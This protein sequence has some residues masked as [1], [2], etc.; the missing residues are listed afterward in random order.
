MAAWHQF[1][2]DEQPGGATTAT[3]APT[4]FG[5]A[6]LDRAAETAACLRAQVAFELKHGMGAIGGCESV[7]ERHAA[8]YDADEQKPRVL[9]DAAH[10]YNSAGP[11]STRHD[12]VDA[13]HPSSTLRNRA[14]APAPYVSTKPLAA[15]ARIFGSFTWRADRRWVAGIS[16]HG[17]VLGCPSIAIALAALAACVLLFKI[18]CPPQ[19]PCGLCQAPALRC[20]DRGWAQLIVWSTLGF[21]CIVGAARPEDPGRPSPA[22]VAARD[23]MFARHEEWPHMSGWR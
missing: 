10:W 23:I 3:I 20:G 1:S 4:V 19:R 12:G 11:E 8:A 9:N 17:V 21:A 6:A 18:A 2:C 5:A 7:S 16:L 22:R 15:I 14:A 13:S